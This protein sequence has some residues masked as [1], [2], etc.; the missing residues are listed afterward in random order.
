MK[1][2]EFCLFFT[3]TVSLLTGCD[4]LPKTPD[5]TTPEVYVPTGGSGPI[6]LRAALLPQVSRDNA[7]ASAL[8]RKMATYSG[9]SNIIISPLRI[10]IALGMAWNGASSET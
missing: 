2:I 4:A 1:R 6:Q 5:D 8:F 7:F 9:D 3:L 10:S